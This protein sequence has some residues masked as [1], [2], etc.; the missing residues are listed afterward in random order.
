V[1]RTKQVFKHRPITA[2][3]TPDRQRGVTHVPRIR[4]PFNELRGVLIS[5][6]M[7]YRAC[8]GRGVRHPLSF[9]PRTTL[10]PPSEVSMKA[11][12]RLA[13]SAMFSLAL[14]AGTVQSAVAQTYICFY[15]GTD[16]IITREVIVIIDYY[17]CYE[18]AA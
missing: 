16:V 5:V 13:A 7:W 15:A 10:H 17:D 4:I 11:L 12:K 2:P 3:S 1:D 9:P 6:G 18:V 14:V 8:L